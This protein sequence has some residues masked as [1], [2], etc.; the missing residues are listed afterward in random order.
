LSNGD[1]CDIPLQHYSFEQHK[2]TIP[3]EPKLYNQEVT[4]IYLI[5]T[6]LLQNDSATLRVSADTE[7]SL[8]QTKDDSALAMIINNELY[9]SIIEIEK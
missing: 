3:E 1:Y 5:Y 4:D 7:F 9:N 8:F 2:V 6:I